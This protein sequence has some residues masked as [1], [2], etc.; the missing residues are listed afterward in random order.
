MVK[1]NYEI[2]FVALLRLI[3]FK[4]TIWDNNATYGAALQNLAY[5]D[6]RRNGMSELQLEGILRCERN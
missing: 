4:F 6:A 5:A 3:L 2:E 1:E